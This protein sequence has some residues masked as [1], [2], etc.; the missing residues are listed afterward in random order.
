MVIADEVISCTARRIAEHARSHG[1]PEVQVVLHG[2]EPLLAG[3][4]RLRRIAAELQMAMQGVCRLDLR[5]HTNGVLLNEDLCEL[6]AEYQIKVGISIDGD[7]VANDRHRR[8][9]DGRSSY[10]KVVR[11]I[12][13]LNGPR[14]RDLYAGLLCTIDIANDPTTVYESLL[15]FSPPRIDFLLP[16]AT[17]DHPPARASATESE[18]ADWLTVIFDHWIAQGR[19]VQIRTFD[20]IMSTSSGGDSLT[21]ALGLGPAGLVVIE[22]DGSYEQVDSLK[23]AYE[24]APETGLNVFDHA[25]NAVGHHPGIVAREQGVSGLCQTCQDCPV[26]SSCGGGLYTHRYRE[27]AG[28]A[29]PSVYCPDLL[30]LITHIRTSP[31]RPAA[32]E[33]RPH[34]HSVSG[35]GFRSLAAGLGNPAAVLSLMEAQRS[36]MRGLLGAVYREAITSAAVPARLRNEL[37]IAWS[38]LA[39]LDRESPEALNATLGHP[40]L[41]PWAVRC[42]RGLKAAADG[43]DDDDEGRDN[44]GLAA[45]LG[46]LGAIAAAAAARAGAGAAVSVPVIRAAVYLP[47]LGRLALSP[48]Q[49]GPSAVERPETASA[50]ERP[51]T[52][53]VSVIRNAVIFQV[54]EDLWTM[55]ASGL[56][57]GESCAAE[58]AGNR[59]SGEWQPVRMLHAPGVRVALEDTDPYRDCHPSRPA[60]RLT[61]V[62]AAR[63]QHDF[64][65]ACREIVCEHPAYAPALA[66]GLTTLTPVLGGQ[67]GQVPDGARCAFGA[68]AASSPADPVGLALQLI[69]GFQG[70]KLAALLDLYDLYDP[71]D[72]RLFH[73]PWAPD[74]QQLAGLFQGAYEHLAMTEF[75]RARQQISA[76]DPAKAAEGE[77]GEC[78]TRAADAIETLLGS[79][80]LTLL[81]TQ[82]VEEMRHSVSTIAEPAGGTGCP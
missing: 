16:H 51:E 28:F 64:E 12:Q 1:L 80:S 15:E 13:I 69:E 53:A 72:E 45:A 61:A 58:N 7:R 22:T 75:W 8:Y 11:A 31:P 56:L 57:A 30:R 66:A 68:V 71:S 18:Y 10:D 55:S 39:I 42:L 26:V 50:V 27:G 29:N 52:A 77:Y 23:A 48:R 36:L 59:R 6:F 20:S 9:A 40:Y 21:E 49:A 79:G 34:T 44:R 62:E 46:H 65:A 5:I 73:A 60:P 19:P 74:K 32:S 17:W 63:W 2:G 37:R 47:T 70:A 38:A 78:R 14:F 81:G 41:R 54:G 76:G 43:R 24:G 33:V 67:G 3:R 82:F 25:V 4:D 35:Q